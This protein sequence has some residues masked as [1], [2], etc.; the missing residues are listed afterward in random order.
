MYVCMLTAST[1]SHQ[2]HPFLTQRLSYLPAS[3]PFLQLNWTTEHQH[4]TNTYFSTLR[5][6][7]CNP[8]NFEGE[9][10]STIKVTVLLEHTSS[11]TVLN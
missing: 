2:F 3:M 6:E 7:M 11:Y 10:L 1:I 4:Y 9:N 8:L 5:T